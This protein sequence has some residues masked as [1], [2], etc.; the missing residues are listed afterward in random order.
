MSNN[1]QG[2]LE[3]GAPAA[4]LASL[5]GDTGWDMKSFR[6][7]G[8]A[9]GL[10]LCPALSGFPGLCVGGGSSALVPRCLL[11]FMPNISVFTSEYLQTPVDSGCCCHRGYALQLKSL[12]SAA[13]LSSDSVLW[14]LGQ[15]TQLF[16]ASVP[17][18]E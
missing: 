15:V 16:W 7:D 13:G 12:D 1:R 17:R 14:D 2:R 5:Q 6:A 18:F 9:Q 8:L 11:P 4:W 10:W 3:N